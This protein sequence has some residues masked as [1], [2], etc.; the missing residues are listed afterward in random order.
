VRKRPWVEGPEVEQPE[1]QKALTV[2]ARERGLVHWYASWVTNICSAAIIERIKADVYE[3]MAQFGDVEIET[4]HSEFQQ[5]RQGKT[6]F[7]VFARRT[8]V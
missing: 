1:V 7:N 8:T 2:A 5:R 3:A 4:F 6:A